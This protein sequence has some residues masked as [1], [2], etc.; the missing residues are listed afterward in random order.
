VTRA[1]RVTVRAGSVARLS[2]AD[3]PL[4]EERRAVQKTGAPSTARITVRLPADAELNVHGVRCPLTSDSRSF[5][6]PALEPGKKYFYTLRADVVRDGRQ[7]S[8]TR[9]VVLRA[10]DQITVN[11]NGLGSSQV[12]GR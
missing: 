6:S 3:M 8:E 1:Q 2:F 7:V 11:F 5:D 4:V 12:A 9:R 10:G